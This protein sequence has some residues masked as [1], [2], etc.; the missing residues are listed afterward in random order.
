MKIKVG[1]AVPPVPDRDGEAERSPAGT[2]FFGLNQLFQ[3]LKGIWITGHK[4]S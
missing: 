1:Q 2:L 3:L 4:C